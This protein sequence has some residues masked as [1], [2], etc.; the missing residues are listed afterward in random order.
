MKGWLRLG[1]L[2]LLIASCI[3]VVNAAPTSKGAC[4]KTVQVDT[5][6][7]IS[8]CVSSNDIIGYWAS[9]SNKY[10]SLPSYSVIVSGDP[11][12]FYI[13][14]Y[15]PTGTYYVVG[16]QGTATTKVFIIK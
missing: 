14:S 13:E 11:S 6:V 16:P 5:T 12:A 3:V 9:A 2:F 4:G 1:I 8:N 7:D 10:K 15:M